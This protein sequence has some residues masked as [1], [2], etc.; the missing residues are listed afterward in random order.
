MRQRKRVKGREQQT[1]GSKPDAGKPRAGKR[2]AERGKG[3]LPLV[4]Y[5]HNFPLRL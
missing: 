2:Q 3:K 4:K 1:T 5:A